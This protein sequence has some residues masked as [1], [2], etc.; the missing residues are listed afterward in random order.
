MESLKNYKKCIM[1]EDSAWDRKSYDPIKWLYHLKKEQPKVLEKYFFDP[2][3][4]VKNWIREFFNFI[5]KLINWIPVLWKDR[6]WD[7]Y[8]I[9]E[10][11]K[12]KIKQ[13][14]DYLVS[15]NRHTNIPHDNYW[16]TVCLNLIDRIQ[17]QYYELEHC[18]YEETKFNF[19]ETD[20]VSDFNNEK[21]YTM[22]INYLRDDSIDY[23]NKYPLDREKTIKWAKKYLKRDFSDYKTDDEIKHS[24][25]I[26]MSKNRHEKA[27]NLLFKILSQKIEGWWD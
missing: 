22:D 6:D 5:V 11:L 16:M 2:Y 18:D 7:D 8:Y 17:T 23:I 15:N 26:F 13:Q 1:P 25:V 10:I 14:R 4:S 9:F 12:F 27:I 20:E 21:L 24:L 19:V 3:F